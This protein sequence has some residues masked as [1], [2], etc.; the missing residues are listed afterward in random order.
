MNHTMPTMHTG[1]NHTVMN[2]MNNTNMNHTGMNHTGMNHTGMNH[3][4]MN[5]NMNHNNH[6]TSHVM[7]MYFT[8]NDV[9]LFIE[10]WTTDDQKYLVGFCFMLGIMAIL[11]EGLK[12][13]RQLLL[14]NENTSYP[15]Q[16][17]GSINGVVTRSPP[18][19]K[20]LSWSHFLQTMLHMLQVFV[21]YLLMLAFMT[22]NVWLCVAVVVGSGV[23]YFAFGWKTA[24]IISSGDHCN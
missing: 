17:K 14:T 12:V 6:A 8:T 10:G 21:G 9:T 22:Y 2:Y 16:T 15:V 4:G 18:S 3:T 24:T 19:M 5:H 20:L 23:G 13:F 7:N 1:M 11:Y